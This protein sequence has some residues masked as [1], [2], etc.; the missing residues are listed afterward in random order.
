MAG[1]L[2]GL[3]VLDL[4]WGIAGPLTSM[5]LAD[6]GA[7]VTKIERP[8]GGPF[9]DYSGTRVW[10]RGKRSAVL[11]LADDGDNAVFLALVGDADVVLESYTPG[12]TTRLGIDYETLA[13]RNPR[14]V[15]C[16]I[17]GYGRGNA[18]EQRPAYEAL[19]AAR[20]GNQFAQ[21]GGIMSATD[22]DLPPVEIPEGAE[23]GAR[24]EGPLFVSSPWLSITACYQATMGIA[25]ALLARE[26]TGRGQ[27]V[28]A[29]LAPPRQISPE[30][31]AANAEGRPNDPNSS[32]API[33]GSWM[34]MRGAPKGLFECA[35]GRWVHQWALKPLT[36]IQAA[37]YGKLDDAPAADYASRMQDP[38]RIGMQPDAIVEIFYYFPLMVEAFKKFT[39]EEWVAWGARVKE[40]VQPVRAPEE[41]LIDPLCLDDGCVVEVLDPEVGPI[42]HVGII[43]DFGLTPGRVQGPAPRRGEHTDVVKAEAQ[44]AVAPIPTVPLA[45]SLA[46]PLE[47]VRVL[48]LGV[49]LAGPFANVQL[50]NLGADVIKVNAPHDSWWLHTAMGQSANFGKRSVVLDLKTERGLALLHELVKTAD[51]V[52]HNMRY[53]TPEKLGIDYDSLR[54]VNPRIIYCQSFGF[55][56]T[57]SALRLPGTDQAGS[58]LG[59]QEWED[60][61]CAN[62]G[63]PFFGTSMGDLGNGYLSAI[64]IIEALYHRARTG[65]GQKVGTA[66]MKACLLSASYAFVDADGTPASRPRLDAMQLGLSALYRLY[67]TADGWLCLACVDDAQW[68]RLGPAIG[69]PELARDP[70]FTTAARRAIYDGALA[71]ILET[72]FAQRPAAEWRELLDDHGV[73]AEV[74]SSVFTE[75]PVGPVVGLSDTPARVPGPAPRLGQHS[76]EILDSIGLTTAEID[77]LIASGVSFDGSVPEREEGAAS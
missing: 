56:K 38:N 19:V 58:A 2:D 51:V 10:S 35:D 4:S 62:G 39:A 11:D 24:T 8:G 61:G 20:T 40:G 64:S 17:T 5:L 53:G 57:R 7:L 25:A 9:D 47:G 72:V 77:E 63:R 3:K 48:D 69:R 32:R 6:Q 28:E 76:R 31:A 75:G 16:S 33:A 71:R 29:S 27:W 70:L 18:H 43:Q 73:P 45:P 59:G 54:A 44:A 42:R 36:I 37:E 30:E 26:T 66:I 52:A 65:E 12:V 68:A 14:L 15:Y 60:G 41:A 55:D 46:R 74:S 34:Q 67:E 23:Q 49:A 21:R 13:A 50:A 22:F 1:P